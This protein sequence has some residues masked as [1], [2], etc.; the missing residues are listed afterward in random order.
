MFPAPSVLWRSITCCLID[1]KLGKIS[2]IGACRGRVNRVSIFLAYVRILRFNCAASLIASAFLDN[3][4][5]R[6][7]SP[8]AAQDL[9]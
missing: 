1:K 8:E 7:T 3:G 9:I 4:G 5:R 2:V 6:R